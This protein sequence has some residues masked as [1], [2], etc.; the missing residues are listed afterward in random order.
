MN[1][2][3]EE[4]YRK[5]SREHSRERLIL[6]HVTYV[7]KILSTMTAALPAHVDRDGLESAGVVGLVEAANN[8]DPTRQVPFKT[9]AY[10]RIRGAILDELRKTSTVSQQTLQFV[11]KIRA[12]YEKLEPPVTPEMLVTHTGLTIDQ[13][14]VCLEAMRFLTPQNWNDLYCTIHSSWRESPDQPGKKMELD[15][16]KQILGACV[17]QLPEKERLVLS[18]YFADDMNLAEIGA[19]LEISESYAS[20]LL[21]S[22]KFRL[23]ELYRKETE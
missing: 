21:A 20:R 10:T 13:V 3:P 6:D 18:M 22:A 16:S 11:G 23:K 8:F 12:A 1:F 14:N 7:R 5:V 19:V 17:E 2:N 15:E 4:A 9:F